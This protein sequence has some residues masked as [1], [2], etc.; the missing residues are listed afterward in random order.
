MIRATTILISALT[1]SALALATGC[2]G[3]SDSGGQGITA[4]FTPSATAAA[5]DRVRLERVSSSGNV[6]TLEVRIGGPTTSTDLFAFAFDLVLSDPTVV[7]YVDGSIGEGDALQQTSGVSDIVADAA[8][9]NERIVIGITKLGAS[10]AGNGVASSSAVVVRLALRVVK[11]GSTTVA[12]GGSSSP[13]FP[14]TGVPL[15]LDSDL[16]PVPSVQFDAAV[17]TVTG[18]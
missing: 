10:G 4:T 7:A 5:P 16:D 17:A 2:G 8:Q 6:V 12:F 1:V 3:D 9:S 15:A 11:T 14:Q 13:Q 18:G